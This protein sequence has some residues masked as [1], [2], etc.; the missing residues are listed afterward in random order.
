MLGFAAGVI[1]A[2]SYKKVKKVSGLQE[3]KKV[4][5]LQVGKLMLSFP[6]AT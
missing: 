5:G 1:I 3:V 6:Y 2:A 4:S